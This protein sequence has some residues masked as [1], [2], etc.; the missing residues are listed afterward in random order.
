MWRALKIL[1]WSLII[2]LVIILGGLAW[3]WIAVPI[4][5]P[6]IEDQSTLQSERTQIDAVTYDLGNN[7]LKQDSSGL[8]QLYLEGAPFERGAIAGILCQELL[9][10]QEEAFV[11]GLDE[12]A[13]SGFYRF[14]LKHL[15]AIFTRNLPDYIDKEYQEEIYGIALSASDAY[16]FIGPKFQRKLNFHAAHDIGHAL[17]T[18]G[19]VAGC[20][21]LAS[22]PSD[23]SDERMLVGRNFDFYV[24]EAFAKQKLITFMKPDSG[25]PFAMI[26]WPGMM[27]A[28]SGMNIN[29]LA[30]A[31]NAG[32]SKTPSRI[33]TP[34]TIL[35]REVLQYASSI[36][37]ATE[38]IESAQIFVSENIIVASGDERRV[39]VFEKSPD[40]TVVYETTD[41]L[42][43][44][45]N[46][47]QD[48]SWSDDVQNLNALENTSS[49]YRFDR[50]KELAAEDFHGDVQS[51]A[52]ILRNTQGIQNQPLPMGSE[53]SLNQLT[54]HHSVILDP[55]QHTLWVACSP[56]QLG[57]F[58]AYHLDDIFKQRGYPAARVEDSSLMLAADTLLQSQSYVDYRAF[59]SQTDE[60]YDAINRKRPLGEDYL[61]SYQKLN[62]M[63]YIT[64]LSLGDYYAAKK[65]CERA[66][67]FY[68]KGLQQMLPGKHDRVK[69]LERLC[70][71]T[72]GDSRCK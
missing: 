3:Y 27:G 34:V 20:T 22:I 54:A 7:W 61:G 47:F 8:W 57:P 49:G 36:S 37:E 24:G 15:I 70:Q 9:H 16:D 14:V 12:I 51:L 38:I 32:P 55:I 58:L 69:L 30:V 56:S 71:C 62:P 17:Q 39:V 23:S 1:Q 44:C 2:L 6:T 40:R 41:S 4:R 5:V 66:V 72:T 31:L 28:V 45:S 25:I 18:Q 43:I 67:S 60:I 29:G 63:H 68:E 26:G 10:K 64:Y 35:A 65:D 50:M 42:L 21:L 46:H 19:L 59:R 52:H 13:P 11:E 33:G 48:P 53:L